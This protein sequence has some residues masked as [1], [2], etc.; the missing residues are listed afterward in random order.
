MT[1]SERGPRTVNQQVNVIVHEHASQHV[2]RKSRLKALP[3][4]ECGRSVD[5]GRGSCLGAGSEVKDR[6]MG[7]VGTH[8]MDER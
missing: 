2:M 1:T 4:A 8:Q 7:S 3:E 5:K 6:G